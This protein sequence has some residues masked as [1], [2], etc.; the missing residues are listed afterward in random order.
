[1]NVKSSI[2]KE[3]LDGLRNYRFLVIFLGFMFF[4]IFNPI[5]TKF[6]M[7]QILKSQFPGMSPEVM[8]SMLASSQVGVVRAYIGDIFE[9]GTLI[10]TF[11][12]SGIVAQEINS[13]TMILPVCTGKRYG[14]L[15]LAKT[16][17]YGTALILA[18]TVALIVNYLYS[19]LIFGFELTSILP[20]LR[21]GLLQGL[22][23]VFILGLLML[24]GS[25][26]KKPIA[27]GLLVIIPA[28]GIGFLGDLLNINEYLP[29]GML[30]EA[31]LLA[32]IPSLD[33]YKSIIS[34]LV[35]LILSVGF[36]VIRLSKM[37][38]TRG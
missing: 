22:Y 14:D 31:S 11:S 37:E 1:M 23:M 28:Y 6:V 3:I 8:E 30:E 20:V 29:A 16:I 32:V 15:I 35:I 13:K 7:P 5:M 17:V 2:K 36:T 25:L 34:T 26:V 18:T 24:V 4:A 10:I 9:I 33:M 21:A 12:L 27:T 19:G 38:L